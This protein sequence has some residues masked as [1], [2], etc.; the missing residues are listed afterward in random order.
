MMIA[1][2][3]GAWKGILGGPLGIR[4]MTTTDQAAID[5]APADDGLYLDSNVP[6]SSL[7][8]IAVQF[9]TGATYTLAAQI[10]PGAPTCR[11]LINDAD[12]TSFI[13]ALTSGK[14]A[15][16]I[17]G[18]HIYPI[19][20]LGTSYAIDALNFYGKEHGL[21]LPPPFSPAKPYSSALLLATPAQ[22]DHDHVAGGHNWPLYVAN[23]LAA[24]AFPTLGRAGAGSGRYAALGSCRAGRL[25]LIAATARAG[26]RG[27]R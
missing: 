10:S 27:G 15:E 25:T 4:V 21:H 12:S 2:E 16:I 7:A 9:D 20:L 22:D 17:A 11:I 23:V 26:V 18:S 19:S 13:Y 6:N 14:S 3:A 24:A 8:T 1:E 5:M